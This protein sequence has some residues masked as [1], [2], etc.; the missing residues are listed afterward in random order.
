MISYVFVTC[1]R[2]PSQKKTPTWRVT[3]E[4]P[5]TPLSLA[6]VRPG[7]EAFPDHATWR[8]NSVLVRKTHELSLGE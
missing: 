2:T 3:G 4:I 5:G 1:V 6:P 8:S 7:L